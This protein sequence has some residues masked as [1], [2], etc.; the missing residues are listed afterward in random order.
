[1]TRRKDTKTG[2]WML[3]LAMDESTIIPAASTISQGASDVLET[4]ALQAAHQE[5]YSVPFQ[6]ANPQQVYDVLY[7]QQPRTYH[8]RETYQTSWQEANYQNPTIQAVATP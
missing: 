6:L 8:H 4:I 3:P 7:Q 1:M 2:L 5:T